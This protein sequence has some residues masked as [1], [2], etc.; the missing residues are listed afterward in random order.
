MSGGPLFPASGLQMNGSYDQSSEEN[1]ASA[2]IKNLEQDLEAISK[3]AG[4]PG[5]GEDINVV[6]TLRNADLG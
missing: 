3:S 4:T 6:D 1:N 5:D 2:F